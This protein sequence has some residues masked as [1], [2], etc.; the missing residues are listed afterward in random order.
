VAS[1]TKKREERKESM[2]NYEG[3]REKIENLKSKLASFKE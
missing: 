2:R 1:A 3:K